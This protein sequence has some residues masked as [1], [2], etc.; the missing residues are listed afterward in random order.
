MLYVIAILAL[1]T[2]P[3]AV[4]V[5]LHWFFAKPRQVSARLDWSDEFSMERYRPMLRLLDPEDFAFVRAQP[6]FTREM[7]ANLRRQRCQAFRAYLRN[8]TED[9]G[10]VSAGIKLLITQSKCDRPDLASFL[11]RSELIFAWRM[12]VVHL[13]LVL[14][15][16]GI[17]SVNA[18]NLLDVF[19]RLR[20]EL[21]AL[22]PFAPPA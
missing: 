12:A 18:G 21:R 15:A 20:V 17:G 14:F 19:D 22:A 7:E 2:A 3:A 13:R 8:L 10:R 5:I 6:G 4:I 9:F 1:S 11:I 16:W